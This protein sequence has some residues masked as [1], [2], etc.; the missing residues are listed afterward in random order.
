[1]AAVLDCEFDG[2]H[3]TLYRVTDASALEAL[4]TVL[5]DRNV[6]IADGHHRYETMCTFADELASSGRSEGAARWGM[7]Y[8]S[9]LDDDGL[10]VRP[11]HRIVHGLASVDLPTMLD[12]VRPWFDV[13]RCPLPSDATEL[14]EVLMRAGAE[15]AAFGLAVPGAGELELL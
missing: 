13:E 4:T 10:V 12:Q 5:A 14:R 8:L 7:I 3:H 1:G 2:A 6:Y 11:T 15:R 9:N